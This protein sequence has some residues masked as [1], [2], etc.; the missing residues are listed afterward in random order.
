MGKHKGFTI[1]EVV[2]VLAIAG[3]IFAMT[4]MAL[5][6]LWASERDTERREDVLTFIRN[7][8]SYQT[9]SS[10]GA[11]PGL[12]SQ[13]ETKARS[14]TQAVGVTGA[15]IKNTNADEATWAGFYRDYFNAEYEDPDGAP[16]NW[17]VMYC[18]PSN[19]QKNT[20]GAPCE[21][22]DLNY[23]YNNS[24]KVNDYTLRIVLSATCDGD[25]P[26]LSANERRVAALYHLEGSGV[27][28]ENI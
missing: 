21:N 18:V 24:F 16:Y 5:P 22:A 2:L 6:A 9:N 4:F 14:G 23:M 20:P 1:I 12:T 10:R 26:V 28:C 13:E 19:E 27:Y 25:H 17:S 8:K 3:L 7:L 15:G 11:L